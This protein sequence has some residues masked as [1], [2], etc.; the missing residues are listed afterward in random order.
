MEKTSSGSS[1]KSRKN[2]GD[3]DFGWMV[4]RL[5]LARELTGEPRVLIDLMTER[6]LASWV[7]RES[8]ASSPRSHLCNVAST[9]RKNELDE[10][11][12]IR[13]IDRYFVLIE[14]P[15]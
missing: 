13:I 10:L 12:E 4:G 7:S 2:R 8:R 5:E 11:F 6:W 3:R 15:R 9:A 14:T 1:N